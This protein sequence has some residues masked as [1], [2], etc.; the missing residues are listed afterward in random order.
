[1]L[2]FDDGI[3]DQLGQTIGVGDDAVDDQEDVG[4]DEAEK[5][6]QQYF[7]R[8]LH[9]SKVEHDQHDSQPDLGRQFVGLGVDRQQAEQR[10]HSGGDGNGD[11]Q[12]VIH[13]QRRARHQPGFGAQ[14]LGGYFVAAAAGR[15]QF[16]DLVIGQGNDK[17][18]QEGGGGQIQAEVGVL[19]Q[20][21]KRRLGAVADRRQTVG[22]QADP[23]QKGDQGDILFGFGVERVARLADDRFPEFVNERHGGTC[24]GFFYIRLTILHNPAAARRGRP[25]LAAFGTT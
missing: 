10:V 14:Q 5:N 3:G 6:R 18:G 8:F 20:R 23:G 11:G 24:G 22:A 12:H 13:Q 15:K 17:H 2:G 7:D 9:A 21:Q 16:D 19:A 4:E 25:P 1:M